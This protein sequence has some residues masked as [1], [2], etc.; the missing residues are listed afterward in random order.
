M[1]QC[2]PCI[3]LPA[4]G[5]WVAQQPSR[6]SRHDSRGRSH[7]REASRVRATH[8]HISPLNVSF[9]GDLEPSAV[10]NAAS[11]ASASEGDAPVLESVFGV[12]VALP[13][14]QPTRYTHE[15][16]SDTR[17]PFDLN[18]RVR[19]AADE[20]TVRLPVPVPSIV[21]TTKTK[22]LRVVCTGAEGARL[23]KEQM[24]WGIV[25]D[26]TRQGFV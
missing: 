24:M 26:S 9:P 12:G 4:G 5:W 1:P 20:W 17:P 13:G 8:Q 14:R 19:V 2:L 18:S 16:G 25:T 7:F 22:R 21:C 23:Q 10:Q 11:R 3:H 15:T 6:A